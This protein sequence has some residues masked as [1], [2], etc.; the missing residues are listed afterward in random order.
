MLKDHNDCKEHKKF[1]E[2]EKYKEFQEY[3]D[4]KMYEEYTK[5]FLLNMFFVFDDKI[6]HTLRVSRLAKTKYTVSINSTVGYLFK[7]LYQP[8]RILRK[9][10]MPK[11]LNITF[12]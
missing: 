12:A 7:C 6:Y 4:Y 1:E 11:V 10:I 9:K 5:Y 8:Y 2:Y 3:Q